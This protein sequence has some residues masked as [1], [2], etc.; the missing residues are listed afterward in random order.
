M[1]VVESIMNLNLLATKIQLSPMM[2]DIGQKNQL[3][4]KRS[5]MFRNNSLTYS[6]TSHH[7]SLLSHGK[8]AVINGDRTQV[9]TFIST[10]YARQILLKTFD[11]LHVSLL[12]REL[13]ISPM[14]LK[15]TNQRRQTPHF[16]HM[17]SPKIRVDM[18]SRRESRFP[19]TKI[20]II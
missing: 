12:R 7:S 13:V 20:I 10:Y 5:T 17:L 8:Y 1:F 2:L 14:A 15:S 16:I 4:W 18:K 19:Q 11:G 6:K 9:C 3:I